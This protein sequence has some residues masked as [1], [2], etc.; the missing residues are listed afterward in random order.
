[1]R[2]KRPYRYYTELSF[3][4]GQ[5]TERESKDTSSDQSDDDEKPRRKSKRCKDE[6]LTSNLVIDV[7]ELIKEVKC[8]PLLW[9]KQSQL[10]ERNI[11]REV[12]EKL[13]GEICEILFENWADLGSSAKALRSKLY[14]FRLQ[15]PC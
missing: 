3:L 12:R 7:A 2:K 6:F 8:R 13:W 10:C 11:E 15:Y 9:S 4:S 1:M 14:I 5:F